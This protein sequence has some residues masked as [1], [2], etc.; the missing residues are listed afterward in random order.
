M[1]RFVLIHTLPPLV[2]V[3]ATLAAELL[4]GVQPFHVLD[5]PLLERVRQRGGAAD[6]DAGRLAAHVAE[7]AAIGAGAVL[8]TCSTLSPLVPAVRGRVTLPVLAIDEAMIAEA[9]QLG[10][11]IGVIAT[12]ASTLE[13]TQAL[14]ETEARRTGRQITTET[15]LVAGALPALLAG[16]GDVHDRL[17]AAAVLDLAAR[18][19]VIVLAQASIARTLAVIPEPARG[20]PI[21]SS[22]H[23]ALAQVREILSTAE[24]RR[25]QSP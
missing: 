24:A 21:L 20:V 11:R 8:V 7:A 3:F 14:L 19:D 12:A 25:T 5:E 4:P 2:S 1:S 17:V 15:L 18:S 16:E 22:P 9:V 13:P 23:L 6:E 10:G